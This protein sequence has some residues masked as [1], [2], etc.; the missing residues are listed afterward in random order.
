MLAALEH[1]RERA[2]FV[3][4]APAGGRLGAALRERRLEHVELVLRDGR[5]KR[6]PREAAVAHLAGAVR[7]SAPDLLHGNSLSMGRLTGALAAGLSIPCSAHLRD[8]IRLSRAAVADLNRNDLLI[9]VSAATRAFHVGQ[10]VDP[11]RVRAVYNGVDG[12]RFSPRAATGSLRRDL[13]LDD[14]CFL[15]GTIGQIGLRKG[16][17]VLAEA[18]ALLSRRMPEIHYLLVG[19]RY[20]AKAE[21][22]ALEQE[23]LRRFHEAGIADH[24]HRLGYR[25]DVSRLLNEIDLLVHPARQEPLGRVLLEAAASGTPIVA[26]RVGGTEEILHDG[27]S[28][29]LVHPGDPAALA[30]A[31]AELRDNP[32][33]RTEFATFARAQ[34]AARFTI[35]EAA[36]RLWLAWFALLNG[37][38]PR[39]P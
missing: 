37:E 27:L 26:T 9:A 7:R 8:I 28:A 6:L 36:E 18:A 3:A 16:Q 31:I 15:A 12:D 33:L 21:S 32:S 19:E 29:R 34:V 35:G 4:L 13:R 11:R 2:E 5:G 30:E 38:S 17:D 24:L 39:S 20:S 14:R 22:V 23:I 25:H 10:G 1:L